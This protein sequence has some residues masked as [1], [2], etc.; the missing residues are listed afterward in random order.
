[1]IDETKTLEL[2]GYTSDML[3]KGSHKKVIRVCEE[4]G[5]E[6]IIVFQA[7]NLAMYPNLCRSCSKSKS[8]NPNYQN[9]KSRTVLICQFC[10][11]KFEVKSTLKNQKFCSLKCKGKYQRGKDNPQWK[12]KITLICQQCGKEYVKHLS[13]KDSKFCSR[14]CLA[15][16]QSI[17]RQGENC[18]AWQGGLSFGKYCPKFN[19][20]L[21]TKIRN[22]YNNCDYISG[23]HQS[24]CNN[25]R[26]LDVH[27]V[28]Y[29]KQQ[30]CD[31]DWKLI[32][33]SKSNHA[34]TNANRSFWNRLFTYSLQYEK[35][36]YGDE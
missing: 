19:K 24:I 32:P 10:E 34:K 5:K 9:G 21:K 8:K 2:F 28:D 4:C 18:P 22:Q 1:M 3:S 6:K 31:S 12:P 17:N 15:K 29:N 20:S 11:K 30:G 25:N 13:G 27:H 36:Y 14:D 26:N 33:L 16:Y 23:I 35:E 7:Y